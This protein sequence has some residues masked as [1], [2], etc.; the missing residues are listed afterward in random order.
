[1]NVIYVYRIQS[2]FYLGCG[3]VVDY[4]YCYY[5]Y[6]NGYC[7]ECDG[8]CYDGCY[9]YVNDMVSGFISNDYYSIFATTVG[10][11]MAIFV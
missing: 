2:I 7:C 9:L 4:C 10:Y 5:Y 11:T 6:C 3:F 8:Y 1:M